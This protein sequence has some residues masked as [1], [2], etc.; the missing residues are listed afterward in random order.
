[1][2][3]IGWVKNRLS[4]KSVVADAQAGRY[5][6]GALATGDA[7]KDA[8]GWDTLSSADRETYA[9]KAS[10]VFNCINYIATSAVEAPIGVVEHPGDGEFEFLESHPVHGLLQQPNEYYSQRMLVQFLI[11]RLLSTGEWDLWK[12]RNAYEVKELW[13]LPTSWV[14]VHTG[15]GNELVKGYSIKQGGRNKDIPVA[16]EDMGRQWFPHPG[17]TWK[18]FGPLHGLSRDVQIETRRQD[19]LGE[20]LDNLNVP[21]S[22]VRSDGTFTPKDRQRIRQVL[23]S[24]FGQGGRGRHLILGGGAYLEILNPLKDLDAQGLMAVTEPRICG[25]FGTPP[26]LVG[27]RIGIEHSTYSNYEEARTSFYRETMVPLWRG[28]EDGLTKALLTDE[29]EEGYRVAFDLRVIRELQEDLTQ[30][31]ERA[32]SLYQGGLS[33]RNE[34]REIAGLTEL[35]EEEGEVF[36]V[37]S[38]SFER[39]RGEEEV[40]L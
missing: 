35:E 32:V 11:W 2:G 1:M 31:T 40:R 38:S 10:L 19:L 29:G 14:K 12:W 26:V 9:E 8:T 7:A 17:S 6:W 4:G 5:G 3:I 25:A 20:L 37:P 28:L 27:A 16:I 23:T 34:A 22:Q 13:P 18:A 21:G 30:E 39:R 36:L 15:K 24:R 33:T